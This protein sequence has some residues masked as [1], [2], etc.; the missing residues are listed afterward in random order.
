MYTALLLFSWERRYF[1]A[2]ATTAP[3]PSLLLLLGGG[4]DYLVCLGGP[5]SC[6]TPSAPF[7]PIFPRPSRRAAEL[8]AHRAHQPATGT[9][10]QPTAPRRAPAA[11]GTFRRLLRPC[12]GWQRCTTGCRSRGDGGWGVGWGGSTVAVGRA[13]A[14]S[15]LPLPHGQHYISTLALHKA[16]LL[17]L[18][19][20]FPAPGPAPRPKARHR[21]SRLP[22]RSPLPE[23]GQPLQVRL[24]FLARLAA[25]PACKFH[26][27]GQM[28]ISILPSAPLDSLGWGLPVPL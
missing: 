9:A 19:A 17:A 18:G 3:P 27:Q 24:P 25:C 14:L 21:R 22:G 26:K 23:A 4:G 15:R 10:G 13:G 7:H 1:A 16:C 12:R 6:P 28:N 20:L 5:S 8:P 2:A 11:A